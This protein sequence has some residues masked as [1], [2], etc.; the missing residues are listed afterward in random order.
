MSGAFSRHQTKYISPRRCLSGGYVSGR[1]LPFVQVVDDPTGDRS[2]G[3]TE[4][5][6]DAPATT[7]PATTA[8]AWVDVDTGTV[9]K[10]AK[11]AAKQIRKEIKSLVNPISA[12]VVVE[13]WTDESGDVT[14]RWQ[15][16]ENGS[17][18]TRPPHR[19]LHR[20]GR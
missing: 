8:V 2:G 18:P 11:H 10:A 6:M 20:T 9:E 16:A 5:V 12:P 19:W 3:Y 15:P 13:N 4:T 7:L 1:G 17:T 14:V